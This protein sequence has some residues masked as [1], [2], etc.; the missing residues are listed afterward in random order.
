MLSSTIEHLPI[1]CI[2]VVY[3][4]LMQ[5]LYHAWYISLNIDMYT[6]KQCHLRNYIYRKWQFKYLSL[7]V[8]WVESFLIK[9]SGTFYFIIW[10]WEHV[11]VCLVGGILLN[12]YVLA[13]ITGTFYFIIYFWEPIFPFLLVGLL[14]DP[15]VLART[16]RSLYFI[17]WFWEPV[18]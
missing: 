6:A 16:T 10:F 13:R 7:F 14:V 11:F 9:I 5:T 3:C 8:W 1:T 17:I 4:S 12:P 2:F 15:Y 18:Y